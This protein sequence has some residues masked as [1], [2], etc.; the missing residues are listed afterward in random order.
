MSGWALQGKKKISFFTIT[1]WGG[2]CCFVVVIVILILE[3]RQR[4]REV[5][6]IAQGNKDTKNNQGWDA[7][8]LTPGPSLLTTVL[9]CG[10]SLRPCASGPTTTLLHCHMV[11]TPLVLNFE[12][13][14]HFH[15]CPTPVGLRKS[16]VLF[17][18]GR[19]WRNA[20]SPQSRV[21]DVPLPD[22]PRFRRPLQSLS[23]PKSLSCCVRNIPPMQK[24]SLLLPDSHI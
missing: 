24:A 6:N 15:Y 17:Y 5:R 12:T 8:G 19:L 18:E 2:C 21:E 23:S 11:T 9:H 22:H 14:T 16:F 4:P 13:K 10:S 3:R 20:V 1:L 7:N